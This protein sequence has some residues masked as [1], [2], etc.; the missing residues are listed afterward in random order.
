MVKLNLK[1]QNQSQVQVIR[2]M[3]INLWKETITVLGEKADA[4]SIVAYRNDK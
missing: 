4:A 3:H 2:V 1:L